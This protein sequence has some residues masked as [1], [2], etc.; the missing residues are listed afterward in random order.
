MEYISMGKGDTLVLLHGF[1]ETSAIWKYQLS[2][3]SEHFHLLI[4][5]LP[6]FGK[7]A[8]KGTD[9]SMEYFA[10]AVFQMLDQERIF[11]AHVLGHSMGG[12]VALAMAEKFPERI[13]KL[14]LL[15]S[16]SLPDNEQRKINRNR[17][18][19]FLHK[20][21]VEAFA[22]SFVPPLFRIETR[23]NFENDIKEIQD[24]LLESSADALI[25]AT[26]GMRERPD[27]TDLLVQ[28]PFET[29][30]IAGETD[31]ALPISLMEEISQKSNRIHLETIPD[32]GHMGMIEKPDMVNQL[33][34]NFHLN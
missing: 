5:D 11:E 10:D 22:F 30:L 34:L 17:T 32:C 9:L 4:P 13:S 24:N 12:Y 28:G 14:T 19:E 26:L 3:L 29:L 31:A 33:I 2:E 16:T 8:Y 18:A 7:S 1:C 6:G 21:G 25:A 27:R 20:R 23:K 15:H